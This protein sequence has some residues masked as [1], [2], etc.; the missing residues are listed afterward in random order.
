MIHAS[1]NEL[2]K[3]GWRP[4]VRSRVPHSSWPS[5]DRI[6]LEKDGVALVHTYSMYTD[7]SDYRGHEYAVGWKEC[8]FK[9][10]TLWDIVEAAGPAELVAAT[11][12]AVETER[13]Q[14]R[15]KWQMWKEDKK[16]AEDKATYGRLRPMFE[17]GK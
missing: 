4:C 15:V 9:E 14:E 1:Y 16:R 12:A 5:S 13:Q 7:S 11:M 17:A 6:V 8:A 3:A 10:V 2:S